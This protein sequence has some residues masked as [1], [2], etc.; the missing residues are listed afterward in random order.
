MVSFLATAAD[1]TNP[2]LTVQTGEQKS[3]GIEFDVAGEILPGW[4]IS[5]D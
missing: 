3:Q 2:L 4:N 5:A 1:P